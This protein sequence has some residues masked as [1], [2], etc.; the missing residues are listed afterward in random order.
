MMVRGQYLTK[1]THP[2]EIQHNRPSVHCTNVGV[3][4]NTA[5]IEH[6]DEDKAEAQCALGTKFTRV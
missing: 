5:R 6:A 3:V 1:R 2:N 4:P